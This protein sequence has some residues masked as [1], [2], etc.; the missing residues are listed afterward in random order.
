MR[1][2]DQQ[3]A[4]ME[5][6]DKGPSIQ[7]VARK[8]T[9]AVSGFVGDV[10]DK[11]AGSR[12]EAMLDV[13]NPAGS[14]FRRNPAQAVDDFV[15]VHDKLSPEDRKIALDHVRPQLEAKLKK[16]QDK[17]SGWSQGMWKGRS[18]HKRMNAEINR[19]KAALDPLNAEKPPEKE[20]KVVDVARPEKVEAYAEQVSEPTTTQTTVAVDEVSRPTKKSV[21][22]GKPSN[23]QLLAAIRLRKKG[24]LSSEQ[25]ARY[26]R[27]GKLL[28]DDTGDDVQIMHLG[29]DKVIAVNKKTKA[30]TWLTG[31]GEGDYKTS[32][33]QE[34]MDRN[35]KHVERQFASQG[36]NLKYGVKSSRAFTEALREDLGLSDA[37]FA[38]L[39][40]TKLNSLIEDFEFIQNRNAQTTMWGAAK[41]PKA[42]LADMQVQ[43]DP[44]AKQILLRDGRITEGELKTMTPKEIDNV[45][46][47]YLNEL[48]T[49]GGG[50]QKG[51]RPF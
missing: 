42:T 2:L 7:D 12:L 32:F 23:G 39:S 4:Y 51:N 47:S 37:G 34:D 8:V 5:A 17:E 35:I 14:Q 30:V 21:R 49:R 18:Y 48:E 31:D 27:T 41:H 6:Q 22:S 24:I 11:Q 44:R 16:L 19:I 33:D 45:A 26:A 25:V 46:K 15:R 43:V 38:A 20:P 9:S 10:R 13:K 3:K 50:S 1:L 40:Q 29:D 28:E 36:K